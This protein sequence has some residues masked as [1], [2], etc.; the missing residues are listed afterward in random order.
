MARAY[1]IFFTTT[2]CFDWK[3]LL[4][5]DEYKDIIIDSLRYLVLHNRASIFGFVI[6]THH[7]HLLWKVNE[8]LKDI[9]R[10]FLKFTAQQI[11]KKL[12]NEDTQQ[13]MELWVELRD[14][15]FQVWARHSLSVPIWSPFVWKQKLGYIHANPVRAG[16]C[17][18]QVDYQYSSAS[19][20]M[21]SRPD[22][23]F[24]TVC[25]SGHGYIH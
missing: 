3:P 14:R 5:Q 10:D 23:D 18:R 24:I 25:P 22:W 21:K 11:L 15:K 13:L 7:L 6:M 1:R 4:V 17:R 9:Q 2:R 19:T 16:L 8:P 20:Y 12:R